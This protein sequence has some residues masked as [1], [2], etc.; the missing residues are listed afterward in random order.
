VLVGRGDERA[1]LDGMIARARD[2]GSAALV[3]HGEP[4]IGK[5]RLLEYAAE[6]AAGFTVLRSRPL[7]AESELA[8]A[9]LS[10]LLRPVL[11]LLGGLPEPQ[12]AALSGALALGPSAP[13]DRFAIA[14]ATLSLLAAAAGECPV[15]AV[16]DDGHWLDRPSREALLFAGRRLGSEGVLL[17]LGTRDGAWVP[18][19]GLR[20]LELRGLPAE[21]AAALIEQTGTPTGAAARNLI[22][23]ETRGNPLAILEAVAALTDAELLGQAPVTRPLAVGASLGHAFARQLDVLPAET[24][25]ALL[26]AAASDTGSAGEITRAL[27]HAGLSLSAL[28]PAERDGVIA[29]DGG[30]VEFRHPLVRS[31]AYHQHGPADRRAAHRALAAAAGADAAESAAW[32]LAA[33]SAG[34]DEEA[35]ALLETLAE[36]AFARSAYATAARAFQAAA[37][38]S[39]HVTDRVRRTTGAGRALWL[40]GEGD[41]AATLLETVLDLA[42]EP[43][44]RAGLQ[45][46]RGRAMLFARP[47]S[48]TQAMLIAEASRV[49][50]HDQARASAL[51]AAAALTRLMAGDLAGADET[52]RRAL[53]TARPGTQ[54]AAVTAL[55]LVAAG[56]GHV[57]EALALIRPVLSS[58]E[59]IDPLADL[60][61][62]LSVAQTLGW[63]EQA[64]DAR[65]MLDRIIG[66][67]RTAG[68]PAVL[69]S[70]LAMSSEF[71]FR[72]GKI[73]AAYAAATESVQLAAETGQEGLSSWSLVALARVEAVCGQDEDCQAHVA[74]GLELSRRTGWVMTEIYAAAVLGLLELSRGRADRAAMHLAECA[75]LE[76]QC[77]AGLLVP[78]FA[79]WAADL[80]EAHVRRSALAAAEQSLDMLED[81]A[82]RTGLKWANAGAARC[83]AMLAGDDQYEPEFQ[84]ALRLYGEEMAFE[85]ARTLLALGQRRRRS[86]RHADAQAPLHEALAYFERNGAEP[87][88][89]QARAEVTA[90]G[91][92]PP[93]G[94]A[95]NLLSLTPQELHVA[96]TIARGATNREAA[97]ALFLSP[98]TIEFHLGNVYRKLAVR[99]RTE[100]VRRVEGL[101]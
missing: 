83:R 6:A 10:D 97:A 33:A 100:L 13:G 51:L 19:A 30:R 85:R 38:L 35:A 49:E 43:T 2:G 53:A 26:I 44:V 58:L 29:L 41:R 39:P 20:T 23:T 34:P 31:A 87:W 9:G 80:V 59:L 67:A 4:G 27:A 74:A 79:Q 57:N 75:R 7:E 61:L 54:P 48:Q 25:D 28:E 45:E 68:T 72:R 14:A 17:L 78:T 55:A 52:A 3:V 63:I 42:V 56:G 101:T 5:T 12:A 66:A 65:E 76:R 84:A 99:S 15:L 40:A 89:R 73:A 81:Q 22:V 62:G 88:A 95:G 47:V 46:S 16:V 98:K 91:E 8:F 92:A 77:S 82:R 96:L 11:S 71:E 60:P 50:P 69:P 21:D 90:N 70:P 94:T 18:A 93:R 86:R 37:S 24:Q 1:Q 32:H 36:S 64:P